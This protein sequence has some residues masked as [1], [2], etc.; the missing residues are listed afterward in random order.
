MA[1]AASKNFYPDF[2]KFLDMR[3]QQLVKNIK[4]EGCVYSAFGGY[5]EAE[6][7]VMGCFPE[8][9]EPLN[10]LFPVCC[11]KITPSESEGLTHRDYLGSLT[12]L[13]LNRDFI[14]DIV[15]GENCAYV[16]CAESVKDFIILNLKKTG[17]VSAVAEE[18]FSPVLPER[19]FKRRS[20]TIA[21]ERLDCVL[22]AVIGTSR[23]KTEEVIKS[24]RVTVNYTE[25]LM[26]AL[27]L[28][29]ADVVSVR[30]FGKF[31]YLGNGG[32]TKK[33]RL[34]AEIDIYE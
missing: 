31:I 22:S 30:G 15:V 21:S 20:V 18:C 17:G 25:A 24:G 32:T 19:S 10:E 29:A 3:A 8:G 1:S 26:P 33:G 12:G 11:I 28:K 7:K 27:R 16:F 5:E 13:G 34:K 23:G 2:S 6:R 4:A 9:Y 14:G